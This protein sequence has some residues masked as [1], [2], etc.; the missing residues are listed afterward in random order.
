M[1]AAAGAIVPMTAAGTFT[2]LHDEPSR[3]V[4]VF[5]PLQEGTVTFTLYED[6]GLTLRYRDGLYA[7]VTFTLEATATELA[8]TARVLGA[9]PLPYREIAVEIPTQERRRLRL[10]GEGVTL[11]AAT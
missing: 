8:L 11:V 2:R 6:D 5:P 7:E 3:H 10:R 9:Y 4:R 1:L